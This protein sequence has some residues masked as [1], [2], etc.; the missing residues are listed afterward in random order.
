MPEDRRTAYRA[1]DRVRPHELEIVTR[2][3]EEILPPPR[4]GRPHPGFGRC[5]GPT[6]FQTPSVPNSRVVQVNATPL[7][8]RVYLLT[9]GSATGVSLVDQTGISTPLAA[10]AAGQ[11]WELDPG[12]GIE[13]VYASTPPIWIWYFTA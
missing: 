11:S 5:R 4:P 12:E 6:W 1:Y 10:P 8:A 3:L 7:R 2:L 13:F 9:V